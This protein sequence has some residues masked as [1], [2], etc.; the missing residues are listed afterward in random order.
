MEQNINQYVDTLFNNMETFSQN[1]GLIGKPVV[2]GDKTFL[3]V[4]SITL[5]YAG[6][7]TQ[8]KNKT[9]TAGTSSMGGGVAGGA[10]GIGAKLCTD[11][12]IVIDKDNL[13]M[14]PISSPGG[15]SQVIDKIPQIISSM[16]PGSQAGGGAQGG[17]NAAQGTQ[18]SSQSSPTGSSF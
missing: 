14:A 8:A 4:M 17:Q 18:G 16:S 15:F 2:Q 6:G 12:V 13:L 5:G 10:L 11:A 3:P 9:N 1:D 7:D